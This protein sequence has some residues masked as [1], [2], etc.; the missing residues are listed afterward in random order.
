MTAQCCP[1][2][3]SLLSRR[4][5]PVMSPVATSQRGVPASCQSGVW[6]PREPHRVLLGVYRLGGLSFCCVFHQTGSLDVFLH[7]IQNH[8]FVSPPWSLLPCVPSQY[9]CCSNGKKSGM[10]IIRRVAARSVSSQVRS[11][12]HHVSARP[13]TEPSAR[14]RR[15]YLYPRISRTTSLT[16]VVP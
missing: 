8:K 12:V 15:I 5:L 9:C 14:P 10:L 16:V 1:A 3:S 2:R 13:T 6:K 4:R 7:S 11:A